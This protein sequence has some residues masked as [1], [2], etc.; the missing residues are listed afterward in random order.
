MW[1]RFS[2]S[3][4]RRRHLCPLCRRCPTLT[5][6]R[7]RPLPP[8]PA[9]LAL[10]PLA[11]PAPPKPIHRPP[12]PP[13]PPAPPLPPL[14]MIHPPSRRHARC[15]PPHWCRCRTAVAPVNASTGD[16]TPG[17]GCQPP[18]WPHTTCLRWSTPA[19]TG[20]E[21][22]RL[23]A[24]R[25]ELLGVAGEQ[26][27]NSRRHLIGRGG[28]QRSGGERRRGV[29]LT[30]RRADTRHLHGRR[31]PGSGAVIRYDMRPPTQLSTAAE[32]EEHSRM[33]GSVSRPHP[34]F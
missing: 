3:N 25:P 30:Q 29:G 9:V 19:Q 1:T 20:H 4:R 28:N 33:H 27:R 6:R 7:C 34:D 12:V 32:T 11:P 14:P 13:A 2:R 24:Q 16:K 26:R 21:R 22:R 23:C 31:R 5:P 15:L 18:R 8:V 17:S 10:A